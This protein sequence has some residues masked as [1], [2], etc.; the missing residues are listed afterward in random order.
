MG[1]AIGLRGGAVMDIDRIKD[2]LVTLDNV[3]DIW[4][5][6]PWMKK[7]EAIWDWFDG[8]AMAMYER[9]DCLAELKRFMD[10]TPDEAFDEDLPMWLNVHPNNTDDEYMF[11]QFLGFCGAGRT[12]RSVLEA[13]DK[14]LDKALAV[15]TDTLAVAILT[16]K[17]DPKVFEEY[18]DR[19]L[20]KVF[21][22]GVVINIFLVTRYGLSRV[23]FLNPDSYERA[24]EKLE[25]A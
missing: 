4:I 21:A 20:E 11:S 10:M 12:L 19:F 13:A 24:V 6:D 18:E 23:V 16:D 7:A 5:R 2:S 25:R 14:Y 3:Y 17:W 15:K 22:Y 8:I 1:A 9:G